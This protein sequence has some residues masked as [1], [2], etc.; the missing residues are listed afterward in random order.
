MK[1]LLP[2]ISYFLLLLVVA[3]MPTFRSFTPILIALFTFSS[4]LHAV[5]NKAWKIGDKKVFI[6]ALS[7]FAIHLFSVIYSSQKDVAWFD[8][9]VKLSLL[10]FPILFSIENKYLQSR[11]NIVFTVFAVS[12]VIAN[13]YLLFTSMSNAMIVDYFHITRD[14]MWRFSSSYLSKYIHPSY[15]SMYNLLVIVF[16][17]EAIVK[18]KSAIRFL[19]IIPIFFLIVIISLLQSKAGFLVL[20]AVIIFYTWQLYKKI[21]NKIV[22]IILPSLI[23]IAS[24][25]GISQSRR[26]QLMY[27]SIISIAEKGNVTST[28]TGIRF[29]IWRATSKIIAENPILGVGAGDIKPELY[30]Q[31]D[32]MQ[33]DD[34]E[35]E[36]KYNVHNQF[37]ETMLGQGIIGISLLIYLFYLGFRKSIKTHNHFFLLLM[38]SLTI[39]F[40]PESM[41]NQEAGVVFFALFYYLFM[42]IPSEIQRENA[43]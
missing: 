33:D 15:L 8:I 35:R 19:L 23:I 17:I 18:G 24:I 21:S 30:A 1:Q 14:E 4:L 7:F 43:I 3:S 42:M 13:S 40:F 26:M 31:I 36:K 10:V 41:L 12:I 28:S 39:N 11:V 16:F 29:V 34:E 22:R 32:K 27:S 2:K 25:Y 38:V 5:V 6:A 20:A 37:L 9:E